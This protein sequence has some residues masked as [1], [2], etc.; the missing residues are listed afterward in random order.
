MKILVGRAKQCDINI[1]LIVFSK[2]QF[3]LK[4]YVDHWEIVNLSV[5]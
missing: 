3:V 5:S 4:N 1:A 2:K